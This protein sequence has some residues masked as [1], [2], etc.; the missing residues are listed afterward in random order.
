MRK[1]IVALFL[2]L[3]VCLSLLS[4]GVLASDVMAEDAVCAELPVLTETSPEYAVGSV[5]KVPVGSILKPAAAVQQADSEVFELAPSQD[6]AEA[7]SDGESAYAENYAIS[8]E[9]NG[10]AV[11]GRQTVEPIQVMSGDA[12]GELP[13]PVREGYSF[14]GWAVWN[15]FGVY[16][17]QTHVP[18]G[19]Q[20]FYAMWIAENTATVDRDH[21]VGDISSDAGLSETVT[22]SFASLTEDCRVAVSMHSA[23]DP[24]Y[25]GAGEFDISYLYP[26][27]LGEGATSFTM[28][29]EATPPEN[30]WIDSI[31]SR[32]IQLLTADGSACLGEVILDVEWRDPS[33]M[34]TV[35]FNANGGSCEEA[36]REMVIDTVF[37][38]LPV[39]VR[40][41]YIFDGWYAPGGQEV[42]ENGIILTEDWLTDGV[43]RLTASWSPDTENL[44]VPESV[45]ATV[46]DGAVTVDLAD[47]P[48]AYV[49]LDYYEHLSEENQFFMDYYS[50]QASSVYFG[51]LL[52]M[53][54][55]ASE[56]FEEARALSGA[57]PHE[58]ILKL[59]LK[60]PGTDT[61]T[62][63]W[64]GMVDGTECGVGTVEVG[65]TV[66]DT[67]DD[68]TSKT[69]EDD[70]TGVSVSGAG[71]L[72]GAETL[73]VN[74]VE[75]EELDIQM[76]GMTV[77]AYDITLVDDQGNEV[78]PTGKVKV[79][80]PVPDGFDGSRCTVYHVK[81]DGVERVDAE[82]D[83]ATNTLSFETDG[84]SVYLIAEPCTH[85]WDTG[86]ESPAATCSENG[87]LIY[88][89]GL[90]GA[91]KE[92][93]VLALGHSADSVR[94]IWN[95]EDASKA[96]YEYTC[97]VCSQAQTGAASVTYTSEDATCLKA[98]TITYTA[99]VRVGGQTFSDS[100]DVAGVL[101]PHAW[102][103]WSESKPANCT[104]DG[105]EV[106]VCS[107][108]RVDERQAIPAL[109]H[110]MTKVEATAANCTE[111]GIAEHWNC[112]VCQKN[113]ADELGETELDGVIVPTDADVH[114][115]ADVDAVAATCQTQGV[116]AHKRCTLCG[117]LF[118]VDGV[119]ALTEDELVLPIDPE[120]HSQD[121]YDYDETEHWLTC[122]DAEGEHEGHKLSAETKDGKEIST[123]AI[124][125]YQSVKHIALDTAPPR[126]GDDAN[127]ALWALLVLMA[128]GGIALLTGR[129]IRSK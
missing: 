94:F 96:T 95:E 106:R 35:I 59:W 40:E 123:C 7:F 39:P 28:T 92:E 78:Q 73:I 11:D 119:T 52:S 42:W 93:T 86:V 104:D 102:G 4:V 116:A 66:I 125:G 62:I 56:V 120:N 24:Q 87:R 69:L 12:V 81:G 84:F 90:C 51:I 124:C 122:G 45:T 54:G 3:I 13:A 74:E 37:R 44:E 117:A 112:D 32:A 58:A 10:G 75:V 97:N 48:I 98:G 47:G 9:L 114:V 107:V 82:Y 30:I 18:N 15:G 8:F 103:E 91:T 6:A 79:T 50:E 108:C 5:A 33:N 110:S 89:C 63:T 65:V 71:T 22:I 57:N 77:L 85:A 38:D 88:T 27:T 113:F 118:A 29:V 70:T 127:V 61:L 1:R 16:V 129:K 21:L 2:S 109:G 34:A 115:L 55:L 49:K 68:V 121:C 76:E 99:T 31:Q 41:G 53:D 67:S 43:V 46:V 83:A 128:G 101:G 26:E 14:A 17:D 20:T 25:I 126:T 80:I 111:T 23:Y 60:Q 72:D 100:K 105:E 19:D 64:S 36:R